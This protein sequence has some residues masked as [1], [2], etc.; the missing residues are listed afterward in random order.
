MKEKSS[1]YE[2]LIREELRSLS[3]D[4]LRS[5]KVAVLRGGTSPEREISLVTGKSIFEALKSRGYS[6][7]EYDLDKNFYEDAINKK[8]DVVF[9][10]LHGS[11]GE[12]GTVQGFLELLDIPYVG[13]G[14]SASSIAMD[15]LLTKAILKA[16]GLPIA[17]YVSFCSKN[18]HY[19]KASAQ[20]SVA[21]KEE[22]IA[23]VKREFA[24]PLVVKPARL[25]SS[26]GVSIIRQED[27]L[28]KAES[29][30]ANAVE[31]ALRYDCC[32]IVEEFIKGREIQCGIIGR[33]KPFALPL[34]EIKP[35]REFFDYTAKYTPGEAD[36]I[37]PAPINPD[38][39]QKGQELALEAFKALGCRDFARVDMFLTEEG[40]YIVSEINTIPG[41]TPN[42]LLPK[43][44]AAAGLSYEEL[45]ELITVPALIEA[46]ER[47]K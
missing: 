43:E 22:F 19:H 17:K 12:D 25:G 3:L 35:K 14:V 24:F 37:T 29:S 45:V 27:S 47:R 20:K 4:E 2:E 31:E 8:F 28:E 38:L 7:K 34:I 46:A 42:S 6:V 40:K 5:F 23:L 13:S 41:M 15:K 1:L 11:P 21:N 10:A 36:E 26:V 44:G 9:I 33:K 30:F 18:L 16:E 39:T 32:V